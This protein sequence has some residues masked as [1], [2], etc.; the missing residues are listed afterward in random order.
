M[1]FTFR[2]PGGASDRAAMVALACAYPDEHLHHID[3]PY[4]LSS[5]AL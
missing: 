1:D 3:L 5:P 4:R 2:E